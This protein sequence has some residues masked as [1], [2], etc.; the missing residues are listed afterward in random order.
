MTSQ[1][2]LKGY[3]R[4]N[5]VA[6]LYRRRAYRVTPGLALFFVRLLREGLGEELT[7]DALPLQAPRVRVPGDGLLLLGLALAQAHPHRAERR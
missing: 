4:R 5:L 1:G 3:F 6:T 2:G 7:R